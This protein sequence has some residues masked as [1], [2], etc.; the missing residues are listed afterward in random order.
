MVQVV[1]EASP[2]VEPRARGRR[3]MKMEAGVFRQ[4]GLDVGMLVGA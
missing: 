2:Q 4:P 1:G 3:E